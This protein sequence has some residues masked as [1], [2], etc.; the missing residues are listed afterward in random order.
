N[1]IMGMTACLLD[2]D[3]TSMQRDFVNIV[4]TSSDQ[5][6]SLLNDILDYSKIEAGKLDLE[7]ESFELRGCVEGALDILA[8]KATGK[9]LEL[10]FDRDNDVPES[11]IGDSGRLRQILVNL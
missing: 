3:L 9:G 5:L 7:K 10:I 8:R 4:Y 6:L 11:F 1:A 2:T